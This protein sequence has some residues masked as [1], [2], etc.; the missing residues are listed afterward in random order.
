MRIEQSK[1]TLT[2]TLDDDTVVLAFDLPP[3]SDARLRELL[4]EHNVDFRG[5]ADSFDLLRFINNEMQNQKRS[6]GQVKGAY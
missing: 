1:T 6:Y 4:K 3:K 2:I 5:F